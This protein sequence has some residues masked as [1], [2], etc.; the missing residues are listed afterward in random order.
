MYE[1]LQ[2]WECSGNDPNGCF[3]ESPEQILGVES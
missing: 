1:G 2:S 3:D